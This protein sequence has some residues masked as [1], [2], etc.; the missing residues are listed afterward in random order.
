MSSP[1]PSAAPKRRPA[2]RHGYAP[3]PSACPWSRTC[4]RSARRRPAGGPGRRRARC[5]LRRPRQLVDAERA[6]RRTER[7]RPRAVADGQHG[8]GVGDDMVDLG[9]RGRRADRHED[10]TGAHDAE[11]GRDGGSVARA[12]HS[13]R[14][15]GTDAPLGQGGRRRRRARV[16][17]RR[18]HPACAVPPVDQHRR[19]RLGRPP[20]GP[21]L[22]ERPARRSEAGGPA[23]RRRGRAPSPPASAGHSLAVMTARRIAIVPHTHWDREWYK[24][25]QDFRLALV[26][27]IDTLLPLL[28]RDASYPHFMLDGQMAVVDDYLEVRPEAEGRLRALAAAGRLSVGP[29]YILMDEFLASGETI[30]RNLQMGTRPRR[31][32]RRRHGAG[33]PARHV[34][35]HCA[36]AP[37]PPA[38]RLPRRRGLAGRAV[39]GDQE[40]LHLGVPRR[41]LGPGRVPARRLRQRGG[42]A[43]RRQG[44]D[45]PHAGQRGRGGRV[46]H[47]R[48]AVHERVRPPDA[49]ALARPG[50]GRGQ[51]PAGRVR[52]RGDL[53]PPLPGRRPRRGADPGG[54]RAA[55]RR[56]GQHAHGRHLEP[57]RRQ[58]PRRARRAGTGAPRRAAGRP[59]PGAGGLPRPPAGTG[60]ARDGAQLGARL[61]LRLLGRRRRRRRA[62]PLRRGPCDRLRAGR[63]RR[64]DLRPLAVPRRPHGAQPVAAGPL[65]VSWS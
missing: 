24:S 50:R 28:E 53:V 14:S 17:G 65:R 18:V 58:A 12:H 62:A 52:L 1:T 44:A 34:R 55:L 36:D 6:G 25:Y 46:P 30:V 35:P 23:S 11:E 43:R 29:W 4:R 20:P 21:H 3:P 10:R 42:A 57:G 27:L 9:A 47:G 31:R 33:L 26:D 48:P 32:L 51:R 63:P 22:R 45:P 2:A 60:L 64:Q 56:P 38:G 15:P 49:P 13:T 41:L 39:A 16:E 7:V 61:H 37:D 8:T 19:V 59:V 5:G 54:G 40:R